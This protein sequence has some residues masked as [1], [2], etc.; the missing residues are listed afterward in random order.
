M[1]NVIAQEVL[2]LWVIAQGL[3]KNYKITRINGL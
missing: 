1:I 2:M 3:L